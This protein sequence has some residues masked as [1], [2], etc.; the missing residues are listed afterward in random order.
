MADLDLVRGIEE[1]L[2]NTWP[3]F[4]TIL[5]EDWV[6]R[7]AE[8]YSKRANSASPLRPG[9][10]LTPAVEKA[11]RKLYGQAGLPEIVRITP[12]AAPDVEQRLDDAGFEDNDPSWQMMAAL[13]PPGAPDPAVTMLTVPTNSWI[14]G[15][16][17]DY[18]GDKGDPALL[19]RIVR[20][21]RQPAIFAELKDGDRVLA[22]GLSVRERGMVGLFDI[23]V[24]P[25]ARSKGHGRRL[26]EA[27]LRNAAREGA[28]RAYLQVRITND[29]AISLYR[30]LGF[31][32]L[33]LYR[34]RIRDSRLA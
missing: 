4:Q 28:D 34:H 19:G 12:L 22:R 27:L 11:V 20:L 18:G 13:P 21:I 31:E 30:S 17:R 23:V 9:A 3:A 2:V 25:E 10:G 6:L 26:V 32:P 24:A 29:A 8:G 14:E 33:Y 1:R 5:V 15:A 7:F 16:A